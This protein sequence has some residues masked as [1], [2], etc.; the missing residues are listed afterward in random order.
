M[1]SRQHSGI[2]AA[3]IGSSLLCGAALA[4]YPATLD[5]RQSMD[6]IL[7]EQS[8]N[9]G[10]WTHRITWVT[11]SGDGSLVGFWT[12]ADKPGEASRLHMW[13]V[14]WDG[15]GLREITPTLSGLNPR[16]PRLN[17][18]GSRMFFV[19]KYHNEIAYVDTASGGYVA[20][21]PAASSLDFR[22]PYVIDREG[23][24]VYFL[25]WDESGVDCA[26]YG[27]ST[28]DVPGAP[29][30]IFSM[31]QLPYDDYC[32]RNRI[33]FLGASDGGRAIISWKDQ[34]YCTHCTAL[35]CGYPDPVNVLGEQV[36]DVFSLQ[37]LP[38]RQISRDGGRCLYLRA[39]RE[40]DVF[41]WTLELV[42]L[43]ARASM[44]VTEGPIS[45]PAIS[46]DGTLVRF[47]SAVA[48]Y[49]T[50]AD[51]ADG[52]VS[53]LRDTISYYTPLLNPFTL[54]DICENN[55]RWFGASD[56]DFG[57]KQKLYRIDREPNASQGH[58]G[59]GPRISGVTWSRPALLKDD[60]MRITCCVSASD[61]E[62]L[63]NIDW[64]QVVSQIDYGREN[65]EWDTRGRDPLSTGGDSSGGFLLDDG[66]AGDASGDATAGDGIFT[67]DRFYTR[68]A[69][70]FWD[71]YASAGL[72]IEVPVRV[73]VKDKDDNYSFVDTFL[74][75]TDDPAD[76]EPGGNGNDNENENENGNENANEN[77]NDNGASN[78]NENVGDGDDNANG[79][80][81]ANV[82]GEDHANA[83]VNGED[84]DNANGRNNGN[85]NG[86]DPGQSAP[87]IPGLCPSAG[88]AMLVLAIAGLA[89]SRRRSSLMP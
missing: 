35:F 72:P 14:N 4:D 84:A 3:L 18:D 82:N 26:R 52:N 57:K 15:S 12:L 81:N 73:I 79:D 9:G 7:T 67:N 8:L 83:N 69:C 2:R 13:V 64:V 61:P 46:P 58:Y 17:Y 37:D 27:V 24:K 44:I 45:R 49:A 66:D 29:V 50:V 32:N 56:Q 70:D 80:N 41:V 30:R 68:S 34:D 76:A 21:V 60:A 33:G 53:S 6:L 11:A 10:G 23:T 65:V 55:Q 78:A 87:T 25:D 63:S 28:A 5:Y 31:A 48:A 19:A 39:D 74:T 1:H 59:D 77:V 42:D 89:W 20:A 38:H 75:V 47:N 88:G 36:D 16:W 54:T 51:V 85:A 71:H 86:D 22:K 40:D 43:D 62:G